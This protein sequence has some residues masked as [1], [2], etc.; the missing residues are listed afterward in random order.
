M[1]FIIFFFFFFKHT[2]TILLEIYNFIVV[3]EIVHCWPLYS[4]FFCVYTTKISFTMHF[5]AKMSL[6][7]HYVIL[8]CLYTACTLVHNVYFNKTV[9]K[10]VC[11]VVLKWTINH[12][13]IVLWSFVF[14]C[15]ICRFQVGQSI[16][17]VL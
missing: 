8:L 1:S 15:L 16:F 7:G 4:I 2:H 6:Y 14:L 9:F 3:Y 13:R 11:C 17:Y 5:N 12:L 10:S